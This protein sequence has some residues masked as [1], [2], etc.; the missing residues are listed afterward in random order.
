MPAWRPRPSRLRVWSSALLDSCSALASSS[1]RVEAIVRLVISSVSTED[2]AATPAAAVQQV[3]ALEGGVGQRW[4]VHN[5][6]C[7]PHARA[8][9]SS[10][11]G[12]EATS[13]TAARGRRPPAPERPR[14]SAARAPP[15]PCA[16]P[17][18]ATA[19]ERAAARRRLAAAPPRVRPWPRSPAAHPTPRAV[20]DGRRRRPARLWYITN[21]RRALYERNRCP[22]RGSAC[23][24]C[25]RACDLAAARAWREGARGGGRGGHG[26][27]RP[28]PRKRRPRGGARA[29]AAGALGALVARRASRRRSPRRS[30]RRPGDARRCGRAPGRRLPPHRAP[31]PHPVRGRGRVGHVH[32]T[33]R[34]GPAVAVAGRAHERGAVPA[35]PAAGA[36]AEHRPRDRQRPDRRRRDEL[37][38]PAQDAHIM[39]PQSRRGRPA[40]AALPVLCPQRAAAQ[41][42]GRRHGVPLGDLALGDHAEEAGQGSTQ[43]TPR[44]NASPVLAARAEAVSTA[45]VLAM[46]EAELAARSTT[47]RARRR[48]CRRSSSTR[49]PRRTRPRASCPNCAA[50]GRF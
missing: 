23:C 49:T 16:A 42:G 1:W 38:D 11:S 26:G 34:L 7:R 25:A 3:A 20:A 4:H 15:G 48:S 31:A 19:A 2:C 5:L 40:P 13:A 47:L 28:G 10:S 30:S 45:S 35:A 14:R 29:A 36:A 27:R 18:A 33:D 9:G 22:E 24:A 32:R 6:H 46:A 37:P 41:L 21:A 39:R 44:V 17:A 43:Q 8:G 50:S 12:V